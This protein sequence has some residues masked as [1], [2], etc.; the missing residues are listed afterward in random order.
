M[1]PV[2]RGFTGPRRPV[3]VP[4][5]VP[6]RQYLTDAFPVLSAGP[7]PHPPLEDWSFTI[8]GEVDEPVSWPWHEFRALPSETLSVDIHCVTKWSKLDTSW[9]GVPLDTLLE[10]VETSADYVTAW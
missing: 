1:S 4:S 2:S 5:R 10:Q 8:D 7:T 6:P 9:K 3:A